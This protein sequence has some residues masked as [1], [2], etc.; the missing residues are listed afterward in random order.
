MKKIIYTICFVALFAMAIPAQ[1]G[2]E[3]M[4]EDQA[5]GITDEMITGFKLG[6]N[7][8]G[9][10]TTTGCANN[11]MEPF[12][13]DPIEPIELPKWED[14]PFDYPRDD[15]ISPTSYG[16]TLPQS[17]NPHQPEYPNNPGNVPS[18]PDTPVTPEPATLLIMGIGLAALAPLGR[19]K[20]RIQEVIE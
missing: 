14:Y 4:S 19:K 3:M 2:I 9:Q 8:S 12:Q 20:R 13:A 6:I 18:N 7:K 15:R 5:K 16:A 17:P 10:E 1:A 11:P